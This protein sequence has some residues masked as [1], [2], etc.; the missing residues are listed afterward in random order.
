MRSTRQ[1]HPKG[2][3]FW[4][5]PNK[6][7]HTSTTRTLSQLRRL[8]KLNDGLHFSATL[9]P[10]ADMHRNRMN[11]TE[12]WKAEFQFRWKLSL[13]TSAKNLEAGIQRR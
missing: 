11:P 12:K 10:K 6:P 7:G 2:G 9:R 3:G 1:G 5:N 8:Q 13:A 4:Q